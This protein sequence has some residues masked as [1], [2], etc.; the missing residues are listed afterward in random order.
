[1]KVKLIT[2]FKRFGIGLRFGNFAGRFMGDIYFGFFSVCFMSK[3]KSEK[4]TAFERVKFLAEQQLKPISSK[5]E[6]K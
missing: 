3:I 6:F 4:I 5:I 1:M 2:N